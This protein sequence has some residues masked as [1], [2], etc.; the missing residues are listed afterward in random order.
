MGLSTVAS[1]GSSLSEANALKKQGRQAESNANSEADAAEAEGRVMADKVRRA[2]KGLRAEA[3]AGYV[4]AGVDV[5]GGGS[6]AEVNKHIVN[7]NEQDA[8]TAIYDAKHAATVRRVEGATAK[9]NAM[10]ASRNALVS[11]GAKALSGWAQM[12]GAMGQP[13]APIEVSVPTTTVTRG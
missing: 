5:N 10:R 11:A 8:L 12:S 1:V 9:R 3:D 13:A 2:A 6:V 4:A 7:T